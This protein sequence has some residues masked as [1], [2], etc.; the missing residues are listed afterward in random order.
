MRK[1]LRIGFVLGMIALLTLP[2]LAA[3]EIGS[4]PEFPIS[5]VLE[6]ESSACMSAATPLGGDSGWGTDHTAYGQQLTGKE[7]VI[8]AA[9]V[10]AF[11]QDSVVLDGGYWVVEQAIT[12]TYNSQVDIGSLS[13]D[14]LNAALNAELGAWLEQ[15]IYPYI[16]RAVQAFVLDHPEYFWVRYDWSA[17]ASASVPS[18]PAV[19]VFLAVEF[20]AFQECDT[21]EEVAQ[22]KTQVDTV[23]DT[24]LNATDSMP[25]AARLAYFDNWLAA[26]NAYNGEA[27]EKGYA[28]YA[29]EKGAYPWTAVSGLLEGY[30][31]VCEGYSRALQLLCKRSGIP[32]VSVTGIADLQSHMWCAVKLDGE[33]FFLDSTWNDPGEDEESSPASIRGYFLTAMPNSHTADYNDIGSPAYVKSPAISEKDYFDWDRTEAV[34]GGIFGGE[35]CSEGMICWVGLYGAGSKMV[36]VRPCESFAWKSNES[37]CIAPQFTAQELKNAVSAKLFCLENGTWMP[38]ADVKPLGAA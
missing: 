13:G 9:L 2:A 25:D 36:A 3:E 18:F 38:M 34:S 28:N 29:S 15:E 24:L 32:C 8:Y 20:E 16:P 21:V 5:F 26:N 12:G 31:P 11:Q 10:D 4:G 35:V 27:L 22:L 14:A 17:S 19:N 1:W 30:E 7:A 23:V 37:M 33:W 6:G